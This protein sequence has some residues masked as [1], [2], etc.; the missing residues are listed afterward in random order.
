MS[1]HDF[2][3]K[4]G[5]PNCLALIKYAARQ[6][7]ANRFP[8]GRPRIAWD[9]CRANVGDN[10][11][12]R[13]SVGDCRRSPMREPSAG[14]SRWDGGWIRRLRP[15]RR[16]LPTLA[17]SDWHSLFMYILP[18]VKEN[19]ISEVVRIDSIIMFS[20][21][22]HSGLT[23]T[24]YWCTFSQT[25]Q[26]KCISEVVRTGSIIIFHYLSKLWTKK[27]NTSRARMGYDSWPMS[28]KGIIVKKCS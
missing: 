18:N 10:G 28:A 12:C 19:Y 6:Q 16:G 24:H 4:C 22:S 14:F 20:R 1:E 8:L 3:F 23:G 11:L 17:R 15:W 13:P 9:E 7:R 25:F 21:P 26:E 5:A 2:C 27:H